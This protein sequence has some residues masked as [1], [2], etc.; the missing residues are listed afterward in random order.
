M[1]S[2]MSVVYLFGLIVSLNSSPMVPSGGET[3]GTSEPSGNSQETILPEPIRNYLVNVSLNSSPT[4][5]SG[6]ETSGASEPSGNNQGTILPVPIRNF[7][8]NLLSKLNRNAL[9]KDVLELI[10]GPDFLKA[11]ND[12]KDETALRFF[13]K[14]QLDSEFIGQLIFTRN[15]IREIDSKHPINL[16]QLQN[17]A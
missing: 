10:N 8:I 11:L 9:P 3:S 1:K 7:I 12:V 15:F 14:V 16:R 5:P 13:S 4:V 2:I 6:G 17:S